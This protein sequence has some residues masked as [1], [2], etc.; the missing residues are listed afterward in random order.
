MLH[1]LPLHQTIM[2]LSPVFS[3]MGGARVYEP[4]RMRC[5][6]RYLVPE[7]LLRDDDS[8]AFIGLFKVLKI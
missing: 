1:L 3:K 2:E 8:A 7:F 5:L 6:R 4:L